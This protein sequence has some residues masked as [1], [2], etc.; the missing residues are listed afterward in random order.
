MEGLKISPYT[1]HPLNYVTHKLDQIPHLKIL[2]EQ[3]PTQNS[4]KPTFVQLRTYLLSPITL[5]CKHNI[6]TYLGKHVKI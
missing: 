4:N 3:S 6:L 1:K 5:K 2:Q